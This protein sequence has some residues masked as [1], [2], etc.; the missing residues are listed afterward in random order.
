M[1]DSNEEME[2]SINY[3][4]LVE[5]KYNITSQFGEDG[6]INFLSSLMSDDI[7]KTCLEV[8]AGD[9]ITNSNV[10]ELWNKNGWSALLIDSDSKRFAKL[11]EVTREA[12]NVTI[13]KDNIDYKG[14]N[15]ILAISERLGVSLTNGLVVIDVDSIDCHL[16]SEIKAVNPAICIVE[17]NNHIPPWVDYQDTKSQVFLRCSLKALERIGN[18]QRY[19][20][21][22]ATITNAIFVRTDLAEKYRIM[23]EKAEAVYPYAEQHSNRSIWVSFIASQIVTS[24]PVFMWKPNFVDYLYYHIRGLF[25]AY[26][27]K[28]EP[29]I[30]PNDETRLAIRK[31][32][33]WV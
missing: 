18:A 7:N 23:S 21:V 16:F 4:L 33:L 31:T 10:F 11:E 12:D 24:Y 8:G 15:T 6:I 29:Y 32:G 22:G 14:A 19:S 26:V 20:L 13:F 25:R 30:R 9:G 2:M 17:Y 3:T 27:L 1:I 28:L 5:K